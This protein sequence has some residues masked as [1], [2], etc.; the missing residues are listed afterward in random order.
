MEQ[1]F[2]QIYKSYGVTRWQNGVFLS[3]FGLFLF[4]ESQRND[5]T[6]VNILDYNDN[7]YFQ[8]RILQL[9]QKHS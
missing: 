4:G 5:S 8:S 9:F 3:Y 6:R 1:E 2:I 7:I